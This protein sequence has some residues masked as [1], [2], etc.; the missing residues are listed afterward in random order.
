MPRPPSPPG[1]GGAASSGA[2]HNDWVC[3]NC[4]IDNWAT[5]AECRHCAARRPPPSRSRA[6]SRT[7]VRNAQ[8]FG[9]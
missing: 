7:A 5:R 9:P 6:A 3:R 1:H 8:A 4:G 2:G